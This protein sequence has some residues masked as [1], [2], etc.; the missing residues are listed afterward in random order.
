MI[1]LNCVLLNI[2]D[3]IGWNWSVIVLNMKTIISLLMYCACLCIYHCT[4]CL[5]EGFCLACYFW[6]VWLH[7]FTSYKTHDL[8][9]CCLYLIDSN[10]VS[11]VMKSNWRV[12]SDGKA[13]GNFSSKSFSLSLIGTTT[14]TALQEFI[15]V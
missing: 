4:Y 14:N 1:D 15:P 11:S 12:K 8:R 3:K 5:W 2:L 6:N 10:Y 9:D 13:W 7:G